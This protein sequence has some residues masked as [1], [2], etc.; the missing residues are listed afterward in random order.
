MQTLTIVTFFACRAEYSPVALPLPLFKGSGTTRSC[1][2][3]V[4]R[5]L[6]QDPLPIALSL[7]VR[8]PAMDRET[9]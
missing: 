7:K 5:L 8:G 1:H 4:Q 2:H 3:I 6:I 9:T